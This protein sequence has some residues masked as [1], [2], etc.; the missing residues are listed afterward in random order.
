[1][2]FIEYKDMRSKFVGVHERSFE[3]WHDKEEKKAYLFL[4]SENKVIEGILQE[5]G[6]ENWGGYELISNKRSFPTP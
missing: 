3:I 1:M 6:I 5:N 4:R 2:K